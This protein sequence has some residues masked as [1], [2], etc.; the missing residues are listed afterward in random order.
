MK[1]KLLIII[2]MFV[3][4]F[5]F[6]CDSDFSCPM[7]QSCLKPGGA[8]SHGICSGALQPQQQFPMPVTP[9]PIQQQQECT[10]NFQCGFGHVCMKFGNNYAGF[11]R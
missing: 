1:L 11:C 6:G 10:T 3:T 2:G 8:W 9:Q 5:T 7:G 4:A